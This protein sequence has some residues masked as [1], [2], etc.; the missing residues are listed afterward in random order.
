MAAEAPLKPS[1]LDK[2]IGRQGEEPSGRAMAPCHVPNLARFNE[3]ELRAC[4]MR[5][6]A[7][8]MNDISLS[9][10]IDLSAHADVAGSVINQGLPDFA[11][12]SVDRDGLIARAGQIAQ[13]L[14]TF[15]PRLDPATLT[16]EMHQEGAIAENQ[17]RFVVSGEVR[18]ALED[19]RF[20]VVTA[21]DLDTGN[22][23]VSG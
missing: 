1:V 14:R 18:T 19:S 10:S 8:I 13:A 15:E 20:V 2:L 23:S 7:W 5:D 17:V 12:R 22:V 6:I 9:A 21:I 4:L 11:G 16:V 3:R